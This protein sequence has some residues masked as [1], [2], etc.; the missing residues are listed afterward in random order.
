MPIETPIKTL[1]KCDE[2]IS[3]SKENVLHYSLMS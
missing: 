2:S 1:I 3:L